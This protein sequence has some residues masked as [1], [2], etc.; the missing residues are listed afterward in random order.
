M[1]PAQGAQKAGAASRV[2]SAPYQG[3]DLRTLALKKES[4]LSEEDQI[5]AALEAERQKLKSLYE[6]VSAALEIFQKA[7]QQWE[8]EEKARRVELPRE[9]T[10]LALFLAE[11]IVDQEI[12]TNPDI[13]LKGVEG[14]LKET[15]ADRGKK[16]Q[17]NPQD[18]EFLK[19]ERPEAFQQLEKASGLA[20]EAVPSLPRGSCRLDTHACRLDGGVPRRL[21]FLWK[22]LMGSGRQETKSEPKPE[23][24]ETT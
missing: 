10:Q 24:K 19:T 12:R 15:A 9:L 18:L 16:L 7:L 1:D 6:G 2:L 20:F 4:A 23:T 11:R 8:E 22:E 14:L 3:I 5:R 21:E 17:L 13:I